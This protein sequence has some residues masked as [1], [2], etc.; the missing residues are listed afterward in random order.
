MFSSEE[1]QIHWSPGGT[2]FPHTDHGLFISNQDKEE[3]KL[4]G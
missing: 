3:K 4:K 1:N 2:Q